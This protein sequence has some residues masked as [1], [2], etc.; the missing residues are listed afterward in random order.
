MAYND[1]ARQVRQEYS[2]YPD[3]IYKPGRRK[4]LRHFLAMPKIFKTDIFFELYEE[5]AR[6]NLQREM[7]FLG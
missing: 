6:R 2:L 5:S 4:V 7:E 1:Y 3:M